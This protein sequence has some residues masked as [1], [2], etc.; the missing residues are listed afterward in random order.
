LAV[1]PAQ[2]RTSRVLTV[3]VIGVIAAIGIERICEAFNHGR[4]NVGFIIILGIVAIIVAC[5][6]IPLRRM[7]KAGREFVASVI[8]AHHVKP[9]VELEAESVQTG[10]VDPMLLGVSLLGVGA[11]AGTPWSSMQDAFGRAPSTSGGC[12]SGSS[13]GTSY[14]SSSDGSGS[15]DGGGSSCSSGC[16]GGCG[17]GGD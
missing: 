14:S 15:S 1:T 3:V 8:E 10:A 12:G 2:V 9:G 16:G 5:L 17:G 6:L 7:T 11:L 4:H 13:C